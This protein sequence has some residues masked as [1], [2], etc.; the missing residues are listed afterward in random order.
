MS[1]DRREQG[2]A[3][4]RARI[5]AVATELFAERGYDHVTTLEVAKAAEVGMGTLFPT[6]APNRPCSC[7]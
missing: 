6:P 7:T 1:T 5:V 2:K 3:V 4:R